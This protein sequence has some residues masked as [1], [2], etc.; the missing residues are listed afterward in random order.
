M[1]SALLVAGTVDVLLQPIMPC[2]CAHHGHVSTAVSHSQALHLS[3]E[4]GLVSAD[5]N[6]QV[7]G[8]KKSRAVVMVLPPRSKHSN[9]E[10]MRPASLICRVSLL[11]IPRYVLTCMPL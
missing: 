11:E 9:T 6:F 10:N 4:H 7:H 1:K 5:T 3:I 8:S 2:S